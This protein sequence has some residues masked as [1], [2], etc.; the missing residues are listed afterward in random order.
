[1]HNVNYDEAKIR[2]AVQVIDHLVPQLS[3]LNETQDSS[4]SL[5]VLAEI[6]K[7]Y[8][9][10]IGQKKQLM[11]NMKKFSKEMMKQIEEIEMPKLTCLL[12]SKF[13]N[14][15]QLEFKCDICGKSGFK[16][17]RALVTHKNS[18]KKKMMAV[19]EIIVVN[20]ANV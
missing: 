6:N 3:K 10:F 2:L 18:C 16:N 8:L 17:Q 9:C 20:D 13:T 12:N 7:E 5:D 1:V 4:I 14:V 11:E 15:E 19:N